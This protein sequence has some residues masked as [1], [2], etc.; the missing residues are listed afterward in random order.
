MKFL[1]IGAGIG[2]INI[3][4]KIKSRG[5][6]LVIMA[7]NFLDETKNLADKFIH[8]DLYKYEEVLQIAKQENIEAVIT[9]Q[10]DIFAPL[11]AYIS[12]NLRIPGN[13]V[14]VLNS[15]CNK[16][17]FRFNC[18]VL[19][20]PVPKHIEVKDLTIPESFKSIPFP[21]IVKP[22]DSQSSVGVE[23]VFSY[24]SCI[25]AIKSAISYSRT[26]TVIVEEFFEGQEFVA[27]GFIWKGNYYNIGFADRKYFKLDGKFIPCQ[28]IFP[29]LLERKILTEV[30]EYESKMAK[31]ISPDFAIVHSEYL[32]NSKT[33]KLCVV[34]SALR[35]GGVYISSHLIPLY[36]NIDINDVLIDAAEGKDVNISTVFEYKRER[37]SAYVCFYLPEGIVTSI[38]GIN[39]IN[40]M[41]CVSFADFS[42]IYEGKEISK[43]EHKGHRLGP[44]IISSENRESIENDIL[45]IQKKLDIRIDNAK[46]NS[47]RWY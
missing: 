7:F 19:G 38:K 3:A 1:L 21:W 14:K 26:K 2:Q 33:N 28:T 11:V 37:A 35:G 30:V 24:D 32:Y 42:N 43:I 40:K 4:K 41:P 15:Y 6:F 16:N 20:I 12:E 13:S 23:K 25:S 17:I 27:E 29:S 36:S 39:S 34:E 8:Q 18:D 44:I 31:Y 9:D 10:H 46:S 5:H 22:A 45:N 47:I